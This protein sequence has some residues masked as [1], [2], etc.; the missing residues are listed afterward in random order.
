MNNS[1]FNS[2]KQKF[3]LALTK[4]I[5][6]IG[7]LWILFLLNNTFMLNWNEFGL[8]PRTIN[9]LRGIVTMH[10]LHADLEHLFSNSLPLLFLGF[11][12]FYFFQEKSLLIFIMSGL[13]T[14]I[15]TWSIGSPGIHIGASGLVYAFAFFLVT[16]SIIK[17]ETTLMAYTLIIV[18]LYGSLVWGFFPALF[19]DK[20]ISWEGH[21][22][23]AITGVILAFFYRNEGPKRKIYFADED[24]DEEDEE[25]NDFDIID[26]S[27][28]NNY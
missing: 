9:G 16:I 17:M 13:I 25:N 28:L 27:E 20:H 14:G 23:G 15:L 2:E 24:E 22:S 18:F 4:S 8:F 10:F 21:L 7:I 5:I 26:N 1:D 11:G 12:I 19:P 3:F 6:F